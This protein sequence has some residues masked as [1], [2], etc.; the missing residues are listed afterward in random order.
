V[1]LSFSRLSAV[2]GQLSAKAEAQTK[3]IKLRANAAS[4]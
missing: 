2:S 4:L 1:K 3:K